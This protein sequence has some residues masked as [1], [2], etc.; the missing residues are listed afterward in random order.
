MVAFVSKY[1]DRRKWSS[2][3]AKTRVR[4]SSSRVW[5]DYSQ[6]LFRVPIKMYK[7]LPHHCLFLFFFVIEELSVIGDIKGASSSP[8]KH[9]CR[10]ALLV[11][12]HH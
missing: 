5:R 9:I 4:E 1:H 8:I 11:D 7:I 2:T 10:F 6:M 12:H 3:S